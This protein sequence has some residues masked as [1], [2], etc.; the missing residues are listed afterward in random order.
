MENKNRINL[1]YG[2]CGQKFVVLVIIVL[3]LW[4]PDHISAQP[5]NE[6]TF[7]EIRNNEAEL[8][9]F[10]S[11]MPKGGDLHNHLTGSAYAET[12]FRMALRD[13]LWLD[14]VTYKLYKDN[15]EGNTY[16]KLTE[17][18]KDY[19]AIYRECMDHWSV[20]NFQYAQHTLAPDEFFFGTFG[21]FGTARGNQQKASYLIELLKELRIRA[22][23]ENVLY[24]EV[25]LAGPTV[26][27]EMDKTKNEALV[28]FIKS[29][30]EA[31]FNQTLTEL[32][33]EWEQ[34][35]N[36]KQGILDYIS[37]IHEVHDAAQTGGGNVVSCY[38]A[39][40]SRNSEPLEVFAELYMSFKACRQDQQQA[41]D[42]ALLVGVNI[43]QAE[44][45]EKSLRDYWG[46]MRMFRFLKGQ[47]EL[48]D[49]KTS[50]H[51]G[52]LRL[53]LVPPEELKFHIRDAI[54]VAGANRIGHGI[55]IAFES[56]LEPLFIKMADDIAVEINLTSNEFI[57]GVKDGK[58]PLLLY[59]NQGVPIVLST[60][61][62]GILRT[63]LTQQYVIAAMRYPELKYQ[64]FKDFSYNS[65]KYSFLPDSKKVTL[66][67]D[68]DAKFKEFEP[69]P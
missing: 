12:Y 46:H 53:G 48:K 33:N 19:H 6:K 62:A 16:I 55:D 52:E 27:P 8:E 23:A 54:F 32:Y 47:A 49:I 35:N 11:L 51:A 60:D 4:L 31:D 59:Y 68:L 24:L 66:K 17:D 10:F 58:H 9:A 42:D 39:Y 61:D 41:G 65:I 22:E 45:G 13:G 43:V 37:L 67:A 64:D 26:S 56:N 28:T 44:N 63:N 34:D 20:R 1:L 38:Q 50:M 15:S 57:L 3:L 14:R 69:V 5:G 21:V 18:M 36:V 29:K 40:G 25:M 7:D 2:V 30:D